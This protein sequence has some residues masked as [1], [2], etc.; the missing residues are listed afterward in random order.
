M[1]D[2][3]MPFAIDQPFFREGVKS[4]ASP[5]AVGQVT[6]S[7]QYNYIFCRETMY[8]NRRQAITTAD[9]FLQ[10]P[11]SSSEKF[12]MCFGAVKHHE[13][14]VLH[15]SLPSFSI[16]HSYHRP[17]WSGTFH[18]QLLLSTNI[19]HCQPA[20]LTRRHRSPT[21]RDENDQ[22]APSFNHELSH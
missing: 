17:T 13:H 15:H 6:K 7:S 16:N 10:L 1:I 8:P 21:I 20:K 3:S 22:N 11:F 2:V 18:R 14:L 5:T 12:G 4:Q 9:S 19:S